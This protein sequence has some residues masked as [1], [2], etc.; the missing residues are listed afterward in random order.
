MNASVYQALKFPAHRLYSIDRSS[1][2]HHQP[3]LTSVFSPIARPDQIAAPW[4]ERLSCRKT[5]GNPFSAGQTSV[6]VSAGRMIVSSIWVH[7]TCNPGGGST[8][9]WISRDGG[10]SPDHVTPCPQ[11][12]AWQN[13]RLYINIYTDMNEMHMD[14]VLK[15]IIHFF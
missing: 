4:T 10:L 5:P 12:S 1:C 11:H 2:I 6:L 14:L 15:L 3:S 9:I 13:T 7:W 8:K